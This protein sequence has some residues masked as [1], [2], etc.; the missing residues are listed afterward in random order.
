MIRAAASLFFYTRFFH[1]FSTRGLAQR[2]RGWERY[3]ERL[4]GQTWLVS[5]ASGGIGR[6]IALAAAVRGASVLAVARNAQKLQAL[7]S[8]APPSA[9]LE[10]CAVDL[11]SIA[12]IRR[13]AAT[14][15][16]RGRR[17][18]VLVNNVGVLLDRH[19]LTAEGFET[20][21]ATNLLG[22][23]VLT[24]ELQNGGALA[25][26]GA[27]VNMSSGGMYGAALDLAAL[28]VTD[29]A[30]FDGMAVYAQHK[31]AQV[32]LTRWWNAQWRGAPVVHV[33]HP[34]WVDTAGVQTALPWFRAALNRW[35]RDGAQGSGT[36]LWLG[37]TRPPSS[38]G[39]G[40]WLDRVLDDEH[41]FE[42]TRKSTADAASLASWL[43]RAATRVE[44]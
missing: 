30:R 4:E 6:S 22:H 10:A 3:D 11:A 21:F 14:L 13:F 32:E 7:R 43:R 16:A 27:V 1:R 31:R 15:T 23:W 40:I 42:F 44:S 9:R 17:I 34:G 2:A 29:P 20:S 18:D 28:D 41:A 12:E 37:S 19:S 8:E 5:G 24:E 36:A 38:P 35:L 39:G 33:M 26:D 25:P